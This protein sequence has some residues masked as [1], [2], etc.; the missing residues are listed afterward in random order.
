MEFVQAI[1]D[2]RERSVQRALALLQIYH[3][4]DAATRRTLLDASAK[5]AADER[6][7]GRWIELLA[8]EKDQGLRQALLRAL[9][10]LDFRQIPRHG[11]CVAQL[12]SCLSQPD[13][14]EW[15][16][17]CL[18]R[19]AAQNPAIVAPLI[20]AFRAQ[21]DDAVAR[22][23]LAMLAGIGD[24]SAPLIAF[25][26]SVL[27][28]VDA[29]TKT[30]LTGRLLERDA[31]PLEQ[32]DR[33]LAPT[34][35]AA[36]KTLVLDHLVDRSLRRDARAAEILRR[37]PDAG[38]RYAAVWALTEQGAPPPEAI[39]ALLYAAGSD[40]DPRVRDFAIAAFEYALAKTPAVINSFLE[41]LRTETSVQR[42]ALLLRLLAPHIQRSPEIAPALLKLVE[43]N[44]QTG[45]ALEIY[46]LLGTLAPWNATVREGLIAACS[47]EREDRVKAAILKPLALLNQRDARL[48]ALYADAVALPDPE[49]QRWGM[50]GLLLLPATAEHAE[51]LT[52]GA[53]QLLS[54]D[55][56]LRLRLALAQKLSVLPNK[57]PALLERLKH[58][59]ENTK[60]SEL[61]RVCEAVSNS[62]ATDALSPD[63]VR[64][65]WESW[66]HRAEVEHRGDGIFPAMY[67]H[68]DEAPQQARRVL[69]ALLNPQCSDNLYGLYGY[70]VNE[71]TILN[72]LDRKDGIDDDVSRFCVGRILTQE[73]GT[74]DGYLQALLANPGYAGLKDAFWQILEKRQDARPALLRTL[75]LVAH[76]GEYAAVAALSE[77]MQTRSRAALSPYLRLLLEN[78][79]WPPVRGLLTALSERGDINPDQRG[80]IADA[81]KKFGLTAAPPKT[82]PAP[83][84]PRP[85]PGFADD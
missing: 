16:L 29:D 37:D 73:A 26:L 43:E 19:I 74:P 52:R 14:R 70:D 78:M 71:G 1:R 60:D 18:K 6:V 38:C 24:L 22:R 41:F 54:P 77:R 25:F 40:P 13:A 32:L 2:R 4:S 39:D 33:L 11:E 75:L 63:D 79:G 45:V 47:R 68:F 76:N 35:P 3:A 28:S 9:A 30:V 42:A 17:Y 69:K 84:K 50:Q 44:L 85:G 53:A 83:E 36:I 67:E 34:E 80:R 57:P 27:E 46:A 10:D 20:D 31:I 81:L 61:R 66:I 72:Y 82:G 23:I 48:S 15:A 51:L 8:A 5:A 58:A 12:L 65:D 59:A 21:R 64:I 55:I 56:D 62:A 49:I 7:A